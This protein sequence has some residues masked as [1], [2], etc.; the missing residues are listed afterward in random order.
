MADEMNTDERAQFEEFLRDAPEAVF[1]NTTDAMMLAFHAG[2]AQGFRDGVASLSAAEPAGWKLVPLEPTS[3]QVNAARDPFLQW[4]ANS[5]NTG[6]PIQSLGAAIYRAMVESAPAL[7][8]GAPVVKDSL[9]TDIAAGAVYAGMG[10]E[11]QRAIM[12]GERNASLA[13]FDHDARLSRAEERIY[14]TAFSNGWDRR[15][16]HGQAPAQ[17]VLQYCISSSAA[18]CRHVGMCRQCSPQA[19]QQAAAGVV[20]IV[21]LELPDGDARSA[22]VGYAE[23]KKGVLHLCISVEDA[24]A[25]PS[26]PASGGELLELALAQK[27]YIDALP[28]DV[29]AKLPAMPGF[30]GDWA[31]GV[32]ERAKKTAV[33]PAIGARRG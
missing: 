29:V 1:W 33:S 27:E 12:E 31:A 18:P 13:A 20:P 26:T 4:Q 21:E 8:Q 28:D 30:D 24:P 32:L 9:T 16:S 7:T 2:R 15:A 19:A 6:G 10:Y 25:A 5:K 23:M 22:R 11:Q 14:E 17:A 3:D